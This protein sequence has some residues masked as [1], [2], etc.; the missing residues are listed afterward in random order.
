MSDLKDILSDEEDVETAVVVEEVEQEV[1]EPVAVPRDESGRFA[2]KGEEE[3][4][5]PA[6][7]EETPQLEHPALIGERRRR[8]EAE[9]REQALRAQLEQASRPEEPP[10]DLWENT[11]AWQNQFKTTVLDE[12]TQRAIATMEERNI[13][14]SAAKAR[15]KYEDWE[16]VSGAFSDM[17]R[18]N[19][20][21]ELQLRDAD[22]PAEFAY[23]TAKTHMELQKHGGDINAL[24]AARVQEE[25]NKA[26]PAPPPAIPES[27]AGASGG[28][29]KSDGPP[30]A[31]TLDDILR[32]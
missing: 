24:V 6:P 8:Q 14:R 3:S 11:E 19:P 7:V 26:P 4:A 18:Q 10:A 2:P 13:A 25:L 5:S 12:A 32:G 28:R 9:A 1:A 15:G 20:I 31:L 22:D 29:G 27:L 21:L 16:D 30:P 23:S 17:M